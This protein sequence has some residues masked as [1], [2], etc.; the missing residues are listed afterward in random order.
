MKDVFKFIITTIIVIVLG[1]YG[2]KLERKINWKF[3]YGNKVEIKMEQLEK[4]IEVLEKDN[5]NE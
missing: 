5:N 1:Y 4:R 3:S 2:W